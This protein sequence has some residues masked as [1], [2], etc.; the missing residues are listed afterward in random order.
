MPVSSLRTEREYLCHQY[1]NKDNLQIRIR[2]HEL[3]SEPKVEFPEWVLDQVGWNG[4]EN[5][6]DIGSGSGKYTQPVSRRCER[7]IA[8]DLSF[9]MLAGL[10]PPVPDRINLDATRIPIAGNTIDV[11]L[12]NHMANLH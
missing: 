4:T 8:A 12:A 5:V 7:Y 1:K 6:V 2:T 10:A 3:Y 9:G 11:I